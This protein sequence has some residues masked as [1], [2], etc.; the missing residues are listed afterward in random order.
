VKRLSHLIAG[1]AIASLV[2][3][4]SV[5]SGGFQLNEHGARAMG[6]SGA[7]AARAY[8]L[9]AIY[10]NPAGLAGQHGTQFYL[11]AT[12]I[13]PKASYFNT[14]NQETK[15]V[16]QVF[17]PINLYASYEIQDGLTAAIGVY[18]PFG[19][20]S[21]W[22]SDW[23]GKLYA[24]KIDLQ[25]FFFSPTIAYQVMPE[26]SVGAGISY[27]TGN[28]KL[29]GVPDT[30]HFAATSPQLN[31]DLN[32]TGIGFNVGAIYKVMPEMQ[33]GFSYRSSIKMDATGTAKFNPDYTSIPLPRGDASSSLTLPS[34]FF[35]AAS[36]RLDNLEVEVDYQN[37][38]WSVYKE[39]AVNF[40]SDPASNTIAP[41]NYEDSFILRVGAEYT[42]GDIQIRG[43]Y[44]FDKS[45]VPDN[46]VEPQLPDANRNGFNLGLGMKMGTGMKLD[47][48]YLYLPFSDRKV[49]SS[50][51]AINGT[52]K[53]IVNLFAA[54]IGF[55]L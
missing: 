7:W 3:A 48:A 30:W 34:T 49:T 32:A 53:T 42:M 43:G 36:Y 55:S 38:G 44:L 12:M 18:N 6:Q 46:Y 39:L 52:Y 35:V 50:A 10:F 17:P 14:F 2:L 19:L 24:Q 37:V 45:P 27:A 28:V 54:N 21:E 16:D 4:Q 25:S 29:K 13:V 40:A 15:M 23:E 22:P 20:G 9:S 51:N 47:L 26:L 5:F 1:A 41:R 33:V 31:L 11:G 8:D